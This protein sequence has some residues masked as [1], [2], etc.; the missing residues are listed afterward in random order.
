MNDFQIY[1]FTPLWLTIDRIGPFQTEPEEVNFTDANGES[2]NFFVFHS[3]NGRGKTIILELISKLMAMTGFTNP[4]D[5]ASAHNRHPSSPFGLESLDHGPG[6]TQLDI[7]IH[8]SENGNEHIAVLSL[9]AGQ[10]E[11]TSNLRQWNEEAL[12]QVGAT[13]WHRFG[14]CRNETDAWSAIGLDDKWVINFVSSIDEATG[15]KV[16]GFEESILDWPTVLYFSAY[17]NVVPV[18]PDQYRAIAPP[19][20]WNYAP[21]YSFGSESGDWRDSLDNLLVWLKWLDDGRFDRAVKLVNDRV[22]SGTGTSINGVRKEPHEVTV[23][24]NGNIHRLDTL[25]SGEKNLVQL[26]VRFGA[27]MTRNS[28]LLIDEP[29]AHLHED[30]QHRLILQLKKITQEQFPGLTVI[31][32]THSSKIMHALELER[33]EDN[34]RKGCNLC[35]TDGPNVNF[36]SPK[37]RIFSRPDER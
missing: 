14:F 37:E 6:R 9:L 28:F 13:Q 7:R 18:D 8:Y 20:E 22:F 3:K 32:A 10:L 11:M 16:G 17:R 35:D 34:L 24:R 15:E 12:N 25:S 2:C 5:L 36:P 26:F 33:E 30:W 29:E 23:M 4:Q 27:Y 21:S 1:E 31:L 19:L